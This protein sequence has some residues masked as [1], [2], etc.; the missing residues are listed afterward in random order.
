VKDLNTTYS[1]WSLKWQ[2]QQFHGICSNKRKKKRKETKQFHGPMHQCPVASRCKL[3]W[4]LILLVFFS[5]VPQSS[6]V[7]G[8]MLWRWGLVSSLY[9]HTIIDGIIQIQQ[10]INEIAGAYI[11]SLGAHVISFLHYMMRPSI[12]LANWQKN[13]FCW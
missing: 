10:P 12:Q 4:Q 3:S 5:P 11:F 1:E 2:I 7:H 9:I 13:S 6:S 8:F